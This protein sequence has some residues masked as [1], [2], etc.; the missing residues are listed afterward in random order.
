ML[1]AARLFGDRG[2]DAVGSPDIARAAK[3][4]VGSFYRYFDDKKEVY[5]EVARRLTQRTL[6][7][8]M[9]GLAPERFVGATRHHTIAMAIDVFFGHAERN[10]GLWRSFL[11]MAMRD[12]DVAAIQQQVETQSILRL[13]ALIASATTRERVPNPHATAV[14]LYATC[15]QC[16]C[17]AAG[18]VGSRDLESPA[19]R[20]SLA[21]FIEQA[22]FE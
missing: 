8:S 14:I 1:A 4:S 15:N 17:Y 7:D 3:V 13:T 11:E 5:L 20:K 18:I 19:L 10:T 12:P 9:G 22:L 6:E 2:Y 21:E 16:A